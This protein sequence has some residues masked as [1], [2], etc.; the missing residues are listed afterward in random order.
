MVLLKSSSR[1]QK[2]ASAIADQKAEDTRFRWAW[3]WFLICYPSVITLL[4]FCMVWL[5]GA[6]CLEV[7]VS[8]LLSLIGKTAVTDIGIISYVTITKSLFPPPP[9]NKSLVK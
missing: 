7:P 6:G 5:D 8:V 3:M 4:V 9:V 2:R 1:V